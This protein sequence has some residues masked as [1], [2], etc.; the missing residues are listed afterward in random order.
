PGEL[1]EAIEIPF[2]DKKPTRILFR[3]V[4]TRA[5]QAISKTVAAGLL[6]L[7]KEGTVQELRFA[8][9]SMA[10]TVRRLKTVESFC[11]GKRITREV[12]DRACELLTQDVSPIDDIRST[13][14]YRL[15]VS[16]NILRSFLSFPLPLRERAG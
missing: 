10:P 15:R 5:A 1:I 4:G 7:K 3:K 9:G 11:L 8:L 12:V 13:R 6:W 14:E 2:L 16:Q